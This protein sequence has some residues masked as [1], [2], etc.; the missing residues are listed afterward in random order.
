MYPLFGASF[1]LC[2][3]LLA[4]AEGY[5]MKLTYKFVNG[6]KVT[7]EADEKWVDVISDF[8]RVEANADRKQ[9]AHNYSLDLGLEMGFDYSIESNIEELFR[10][11]S[12]NE[13]VRGAIQKLKPSQRELITAIYFEGISVNTYAEIYGVD[14]SAISHRLRTA[15]NNLKKLL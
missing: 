10:E 11:P 8:D 7:F 1:F 3:R 9:R 15:K 2:I 13:R 4:R 14:H 12:T 6:E 5:E